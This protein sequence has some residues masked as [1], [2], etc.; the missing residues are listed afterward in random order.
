MREKKKE[1]PEGQVLL[2][3]D[4]E[5]FASALRDKL[6]KAGVTCEWRNNFEAGKQALD[7][8]VFHALVVDMYLSPERPEGLELVEIAKNVGIPSVIITSRLDLDIAKQGLNNGADF[9]IEKPFQVRDLID[10]LQELWNNPRGLISRR[11][12]FF[13]TQHLT[14][15]ERELARLLLKGLSNQEIAD[16]SQ[17]T[18]STVKFYTNQIFQKCE[19]K[20]RA[21]LFNTI[22]PT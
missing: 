16:V 9:L 21:E 4:D 12:R 22:F 6:N 14:D 1:A 18:L 19:V 8:S 15:K 20:S 11:E 3:D 5:L 7:Q 10:I 13:E 17:T 2:V